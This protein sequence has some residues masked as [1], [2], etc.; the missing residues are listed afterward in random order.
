MEPLKTSAAGTRARLLQAAQRLLEQEGLDAVTLRAVGA[1]AAVS[2]GAPYRHF[3]DKQDM[4]AAVAAQAMTRQ[5]DGMA[6]A[7]AASLAADGDSLAALRA[8]LTAYIE[9]ALAHPALYRMIFGP[10]RAPAEHAELTAA[11]AM[12]HA[13]LVRAVEEA[14][15]AGR[16]PAAEPAELAAVFWAATHG[17]IDLTV[18]GHA[19]AA[20]G[21]RDPAS[22][23]A[24]MLQ[25][26]AGD[27]APLLGGTPLA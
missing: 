2:R 18:S 4:L 23:L 5:R 7:R 25:L 26:M 14:Q 10:T 6:E 22:V 3:A 11:G 12:A 20:K 27:S 9:E 24:L 1:G 17:L 8:M 19:T 15:A 21:V 13:L 16:L